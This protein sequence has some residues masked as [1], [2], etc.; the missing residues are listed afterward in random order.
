MKYMTLSKQRRATVHRKK[1]S[2]L[3]QVSCTVQET[4]D[5]FAEGN[6]LLK[7][8]DKERKARPPTTGRREDTSCSVKQTWNTEWKFSTFCIRKSPEKRVTNLQLNWAI[9]DHEAYV[10]QV[11]WYSD[12]LW[13]IHKLQGSA[14]RD[15]SL[16]VVSKHND[17]NHPVSLHIRVWKRIW[18]T[19]LDSWLRDVIQTVWIAACCGKD[20][21]CSQKGFDGTSKAD[22][23]IEKSLS[24]SSSSAYSWSRW[25]KPHAGSKTPCQLK[26]I[27]GWQPVP[28]S[29]HACEDVQLSQ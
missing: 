28:C 2:P 3:E 13:R 5:P 6:L 4:T 11:G 23:Q 25:R 14:R 26:R 7:Q 19:P 1:L 24:T 12:N 9:S 22:A 20:L 29:Q 18:P 27:H 17:W 16:Q 15:T 8:R 21:F 10:G